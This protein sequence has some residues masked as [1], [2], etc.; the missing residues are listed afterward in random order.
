MR[1]TDQ[2]VD[3]KQELIDWLSI[4]LR[5]VMET[6]H[7]GILSWVLALAVVVLL[8]W[9]KFRNPILSWRLPLTGTVISALLL[10][11]SWLSKPK[12][13]IAVNVEPSS[14][15]YSEPYGR[16]KRIVLLSEG[17]AGRLVRESDGWFYV[18]LGDG[19]LAWFNAE[20]WERVLHYKAN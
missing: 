11:A 3:P 15:G 16:G 12:S 6:Q 9:R 2:M 19:R 13:F 4:A 8:L 5:S 7:W 1:L 10:L 17:T 18:E 14:Y 20:E